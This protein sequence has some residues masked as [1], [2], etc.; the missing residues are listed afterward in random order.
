M[1]VLTSTG[2]YYWIPMERVEL[3]EFRP[4][5]RPRDLLWR[6]S[7]MVVRGGPD[8]EVFLPGLYFGSHADEDDRVRLGRYT[9]WRGGDGTPTRGIGQ[10]VF[11]VG[12]SDQAILELQNISIASEAEDADDAQS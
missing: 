6:R 5:E 4:P 11:L 3:I 10:R 7:H 2:K 9:D 12:D 8:G 1:M